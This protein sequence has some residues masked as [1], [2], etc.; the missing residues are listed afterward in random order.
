MNRRIALLGALASSV[1]AASPFT[2]VVLGDR[3]GNARQEVFEQVLDEVRVLK[4]DLLVNV[5]DLVEGYT[6]SRDTLVQ[7]WDTIVKQLKATGI[8]YYLTPG[9]HDITDAMSETVY[10]QRIGR[11]FYSFN[12]SECHFVVLDNSRWDSASVLPAAQLAWLEQDL[13]SNRA[14]RWTFVFMHRSFWR[15]AKRQGRPDTLH[16]LFKANGVDYVFSGH[17]HY[18]CQTNWDGIVYTQL[19]PSGSRFKTYVQEE[20]GAFQN[21]LFLRVSDGSVTP[22]VIKPGNILALDAVTLEDEILLDSIDRI[23]VTVPTIALATDQPVMDS[24]AITVTNVLADVLT[25]SCVWQLPGSNWRVEPETVVVA[26]NP[27]VSRSASYRV[28]LAAGA[29]PYPLPEFNLVYPYAPAKQYRINRLLPIR[30]EAVCPRIP[31]PKLDGNLNDKCWKRVKPLKTFGSSEGKAMPTEPL[32]VYFAYDDTMFY[33]AAR[34]TESQMAGLRVEATERDGRVAND[35][36]LNFLLNPNPDLPVYY[37]LIINP[38]GVIWDRRCWIEEGKSVRDSKWN[39][40]WRIATATGKNFWSVEIA[41]PLSNVGLY[42]QN[43][44]FNIARFQSRKKAVA[45][46]QAPFLHETDRF[47]RLKLTN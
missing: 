10:V 38:Q 28:E 25:T 24:L 8:R 17:D 2:M 26:A 14:A 11:P 34:C 9:N 12:Y 1:L 13:A 45:V 18:Y 33:L 42:R 44:D 36:N 31:A 23:G 15:E 43:W 27:G 16:K 35:D 40:D 7:Q 19:G 41:L 30:R 39:G 4:P 37:Q 20:R 32:E 21:Y 46:F 6:K 5:G 29:D 47:A 3:T 22:V